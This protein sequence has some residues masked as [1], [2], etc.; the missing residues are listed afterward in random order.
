MC[1]I[2]LDFGLFQSYGSINKSNKDKA[3]S[4]P[5]MCEEA[6]HALSHT[7]THRIMSSFA[8][9]NSYVRGETFHLF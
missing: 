7:P 8:C 5:I 4:M 1:I 9:L 6:L 3:C 2:D